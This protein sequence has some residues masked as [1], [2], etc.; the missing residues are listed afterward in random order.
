MCVQS[1]TEKNKDKSKFDKHYTKN[2]MRNVKKQTKCNN[3]EQSGKRERDGESDREGGRERETH[4]SEMRSSFS[5]CRSELERFPMHGTNAVYAKHV[6][7]QS[8][9]TTPHTGARE[10]RGST[11][12]SYFFRCKARARIYYSKICYTIAL[13]V[14]Q[15]N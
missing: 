4:V 5:V 8:L 7:L 9:P 12:R 3:R 10:L 6:S 15:Q 14:P 1:A 11:R 2:E 13:Q